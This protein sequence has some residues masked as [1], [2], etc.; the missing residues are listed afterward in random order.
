MKVTSFGIQDHAKRHQYYHNNLSIQWFCQL[1]SHI[2]LSTAR[3]ANSTPTA[4]A[5]RSCCKDKG[6]H[7]QVHIPIHDQYESLVMVKYQ[8]QVN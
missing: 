3:L 2:F 5:E 8:L 1:I 6:I 4:G 7:N